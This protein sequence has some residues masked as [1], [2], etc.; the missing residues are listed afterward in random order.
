MTDFIVI[1]PGIAGSALEKDGEEMWGPGVV[2][3]TLWNLGGD[4]NRPKLH[5]K[6]RHNILTNVS[7]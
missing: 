7:D 3:D 1:N 6:I 4:L 5:A 2:W